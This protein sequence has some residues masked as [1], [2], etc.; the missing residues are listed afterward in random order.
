MEL[1]LEQ[2]QQQKLSAQ[3][4]QSME[5]LQMSTLE[6]QEYVEE[7]L[8]ENPVLE[9]EDACSQEEGSELLHKLEWLA[10]NS[11]QGRHSRSD[12]SLELANAVAAP[13][14]ESLYDHLGA[15]IPWNYL[16]PAVC[17]GIEGVLT[18][19]NDNGWLEESAE[20]LAR[21]CGVSSEVIS[22]AE[23]IVQNLEPA[24]V[25]A[26][27][28]QQCL[29]LQL[30]RRGEHGLALTI[31]KHHLEDMAKNHYHQIAR[32]TGASREEIQHA[33]RLIRSLDPKPGA[34]FAPREVS[35]YVNP[36]LIVWEENG[37]LDVAFLERNSP[38][39]HIS[40]YY[41][42]LLHSSEDTQVKTYLHEKLRQAD[43]VIQ[44]I[45]QRK[46]T[47]L[48]CA[49]CIVQRQEAFFLRGKDHLSPL[50]QADVASALELHESTISRAIRDKYI[51]CSWGTFPMSFFFSR[52]L[53]GQENVS[54]SRVK[55]ILRDLIAGEDKAKPLSDQKL[56]DM[57]ATQ[58][59]TVSRRT[60]AKY[61]DEMGLPSAPGRKE[62]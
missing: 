25:G 42:D 1:I 2:K 61:R 29:K 20:E 16:S 49:R 13:A 47:V 44:N 41:R 21:R 55:S 6:L 60:V 46:N 59:L 10:A 52:A 33:C 28:L 15:Q 5:V 56:C 4:I 14:D 37:T 48:R 38:M 57:L 43:W 51:Q 58:G 40:P 9:R 34:A 39:I 22:G 53:A 50:T 36:D 35:S 7:L 8:L 23:I 26:R 27:T 32:A 11:R 18:G 30:L 19:L 54:T 45:E 31:V 3:M 24:G 62:F 17:R 12:R